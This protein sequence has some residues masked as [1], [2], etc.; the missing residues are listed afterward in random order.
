MYWVLLPLIAL[1]TACIYYNHSSSGLLKLYPLIFLLIAGMVFIFVYFYRA[2]KISYDEI[3]Y[4]G[5]FSSRD[6]AIINAGKTLILKKLRGNR[7]QITLFGNDGVLPDLDWMKSTGESPRD[8]SLF[9]GKV[10]WYNHSVK[11]ILRYF[12]F[13]NAAC[14]QI[15][16][17]EVKELS[18]TLATV[19]VDSESETINIR[20]NKT[21]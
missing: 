13:D 15:L 4:I 14:N 3:K 20:I 21:I 17:G 10:I 16:S 1:L 8:I 19:T 2:V 7:L 6:S 9:R 12:D 18:S 11:R 5:R